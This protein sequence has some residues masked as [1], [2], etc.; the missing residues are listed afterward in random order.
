MPMPMPK[1]QERTK[2]YKNTSSQGLL[3]LGL[4]PFRLLDNVIIGIEGVHVIFHRIQVTEDGVEDETT[5]EGRTGKT[6]EHPHDGGI[7]G[8]GSEG[9][10]ESG[11]EG[12]RE[13]V[14]RLHEGLHARRGLGVGVLETGDGGENLRHTDEH[15]G[16]GLNGDV[17]SVALGG[18]IDLG[19]CAQR[20]AVAGSGG[21]DQVLHNSG[22]HHGKRGD[23]E[24]KG[25]T[26]DRGEGDLQ[27]AHH[28]VDAGFENGNENNDRNGVKVLHQ[29]VRN[30]VAF[31][32]AGLGDE[33]AGE[34]SVDNPVD[35]VE[36]EHAAGDQ[37][38]LQLVDEVVVPVDSRHAIVL[39]LP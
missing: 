14:H 35:R 11:S 15:V 39:V 20:V 6:G 29:I 38:A 30:A 19:G 2:Y 8:G 21:V 23:D 27:A 1:E 24:T 12:V 5:Q 25:D 16:R 4:A 33:V 37:G 31:H 3:F 18:A 26:G 7:E 34:L 36:G 17:H 10:G 13:E 22:V 32:L 9:L 28:G